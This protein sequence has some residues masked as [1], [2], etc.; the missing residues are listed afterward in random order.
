M[1][2]FFIGLILIFFLSSAVFA[3][4][5]VMENGDRLTGKIV[6]KDGDSV[7]IQTELAGTVKIKWSSVVRIVSEEPLTLTLDDG[8]VVEGKFEDEEGKIKVEIEEK[9]K[10]TVEK[11]AVKVVRTIEDQKK[12]EIEQRRI[13]VSKLTDFW[14]GTVDVGFSMTSGN[15]DTR[16]FSAGLRGVRET[17]KNKFTVYANALQIKDTSNNNRKITA[18]SVW[19]GAR[20]DVDLNRKWFAFGSGDF[21]YN[22]PQKL[23]LRAVLG[24]GLGY[25]AVRKDRINFDVTSGVTNNYENFSTGI[26]RNSAEL[27]FG[28]ELKFKI[29]SRVRLTERAVFYPNLSRM[30][31]I[32]ALFDASVQTDINSWLGWHLT[33]GNRFNSRPVDRTERNDFLLSTG[34]R[35][36]FGKNK[37][38]LGK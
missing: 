18:Q 19:T 35:F 9:K 24:G 8:K 22:K 4:Q 38:R 15:S 16:T 29:N 21:E 10:M 23:N 25:H 26:R 11:K 3:D 14:S 33:V 6:R 17:R 12:Y 30:G 34:I 20:H 31:D 36:S 27:L 7:T 37:K 1:P 2:K 13:E 5:I 32:R 28:E